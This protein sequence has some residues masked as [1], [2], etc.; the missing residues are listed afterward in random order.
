MATEGKEN[1]K[2]RGG[3]MG[4][5]PRNLEKK[6]YRRRNLIR[7]SENVEERSGNGKIGNNKE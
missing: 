7:G 1:K 5:K 4:E 2:E 3:W 6:T